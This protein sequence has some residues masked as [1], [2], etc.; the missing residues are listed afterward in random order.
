[1]TVINNLNIGLRDTSICLGQ[2]VTL[3]AGNIGA[4]YSWSTGA[5]TQT[6][7]VTQGNTYSVLVT[8]SGGCSKR[9]TAVVTVLPLPT[10][11]L[12]LID[13]VSLNTHITYLVVGENVHKIAV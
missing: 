13:T 7:S 9:D 6:I 12:S 4:S 3:N 2:S 10:V 5:T 8:A 11:T 1:M